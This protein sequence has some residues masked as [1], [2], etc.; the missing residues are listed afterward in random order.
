MVPGR[1]APLSLQPPVPAQLYRAPSRRGPAAP[2]GLFPAHPLG[3]GAAGTGGNC[4]FG[5]NSVPLR[6]AGARREGNTA[7]GQQRAASARLAAPSLWPLTGQEMGQR[8]QIPCCAPQSLLGLSLASL[9]G[10]RRARRHAG[11]IS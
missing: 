11:S 10:S 9:L 1:A 6:A 7:P 2:P 5:V 3:P 8:G 4:G